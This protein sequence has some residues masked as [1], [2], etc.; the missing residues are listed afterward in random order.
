MSGT[1]IS[2]VTT[3]LGRALAARLVARG[4]VL[5]VGMDPVERMQSTFP[6]GVTYHQVDLTR[7]R[8]MRR[9]LFGPARDLGIESVVHL[10]VHRSAR[11]RGS[12]AHRL[13][14]DAT[15]L[16]LR[17]SE[18]HPSI[19][20]FVHYSTGA[21]YQRKARTPDLIREDQPVEMSPRAP[22]WVRDRVEADVTVC[23]RMGLSPLH[24]N[25]LRCAEILAPDMG[26]QL[27]DYLSSRVCLRSL[28]FDPVLNL[29]SLDDAARALELALD[30]TEPGIINIPGADTL[31]LS[32]AIRLW[33]RDDIPVPAPVLGPMYRLRAKVRG[34]EFDYE[35]NAARFHYNAVLDGDRA[36][37]LLGYEP[38]VGVDWPGGRAGNAAAR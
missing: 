23:A 5:G 16:M 11:A 25:V 15:R 38:E 2:G 33:G 18:D 30:A 1:L 29:L 14:V 32:R 34:T 35:M 20:R 21:V 24:V 12:K 26:S 19:Q 36:R 8:R 22:Q 31:T 7:P 28:G 27:F 37:R 3:P 13:N 4:P 10:A 17:L 6:D 9:L